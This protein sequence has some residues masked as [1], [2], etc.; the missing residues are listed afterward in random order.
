MSCRGTLQCLAVVNIIMVKTKSMKCLAIFWS[1]I[2]NFTV[3]MSGGNWWAPYRMWPSHCRLLLVERAQFFPCYLFCAE[4]LA[5]IKEQQ[6][7]TWN[8]VAELNLQRYTRLWNTDTE[9]GCCREGNAAAEQEVSSLCFLLRIT[10]KINHLAAL[11][12]SRTGNV[13]FPK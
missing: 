6:E 3:L 10:E 4:S 5:G 13:H 11:K 12:T 8:L 9:P 1:T 2:E 7:Y